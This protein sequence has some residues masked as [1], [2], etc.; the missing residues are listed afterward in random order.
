MK[1]RREHD[2]SDEAPIFIVGPSRSGTSMVRELLNGQ[3]S[4]WITR[5]THYF[6]D[7][8][9]RFR[10]RERGPL[11]ADEKRRCEAYFLARGHLAYGAAATPELSSIDRE[12]LA[13][14]AER[15]GSG[16]DAYFEAFC[17]LRARANGKTGWGEKTPRHAFRIREMVTAFPLARIVCLIRDPRAVVASVFAIGRPGPRLRPNW[18]HLRGRSASGTPLLSCCPRV[19]DVAKRNSGFAGGTQAV[20]VGAHPAPEL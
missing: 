16:P 6:D 13:C 8:R 4:L 3:D 12:D 15:L 2:F 17:R 5:E 11:S 14:E 19:V 20:R 18:R 9:V 7:L 1:R 10:G